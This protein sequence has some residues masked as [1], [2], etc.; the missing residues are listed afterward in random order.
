MKGINFS[1]IHLMG[2]LTF[3]L[4]SASAYAEQS[5]WAGKKEILGT[6][7]TVNEAKLAFKSQLS[8]LE[9]ACQ[10]EEGTALIAVDPPTLS[11]GA[12][13]DFYSSNNYVV[14]QKFDCVK[15]EKP[16]TSNS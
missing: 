2:I 5:I 7:I 9:T 15:K 6:G 13:I 8:T 4:F 12:S 10:A 3:S 14:R 1:M 16:E 11:W